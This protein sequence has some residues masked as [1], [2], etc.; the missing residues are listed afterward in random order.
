VPSASRRAGAGSRQDAGGTSSW[1]VKHIVRLIVTSS[2]YKQSSKLRPELREIDPNNR[3]LAS[4]N[5]RR[6][7]AEFVRDN[8]L[9]ISG[10]LNPELGGPSA[11]PY[12]PAGYYVNLQFPDRDYHADKD[13]RQYRRGVYAHWQRTFLQPML[14]NFDAPSREECTAIRTL[15]NTPQQA[16]TLLN[17]PTFVEAARVL[18]QKLLQSAAKSDAERLDFACQRALG[19]SI[20]PKELA[21]LKN[22]LA[23]QRE[24]LRSDQEEAV[25][26]Q[27]VGLAPAAKDGDEMELGAWTSVCRVILNLHEVIT[28]Y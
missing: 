10:L 20:K 25:K 17:D 22:F 4:Q 13:E 28:V 16:L 7:E 15:S 2:T 5:P 3:L 19:R 11:H 18:A 9:A 8:A 14:A 23:A 27:K 24:H 1:D 6:L 21:S 12:Q 26:I